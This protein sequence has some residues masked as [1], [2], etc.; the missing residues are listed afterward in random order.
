M[1]Q[2]LGQLW[3]FRAATTDEMSRGIDLSKQFKASY[4]DIA[5]WYQTGTCTFLLD[6]N[7]KK[8]DKGSI[9]WRDHKGGR[10]F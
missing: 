8:E 5:F 6:K 4:I 3:S 9:V 1:L 10:A 7:L 2:S